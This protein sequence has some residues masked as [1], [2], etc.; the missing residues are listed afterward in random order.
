MFAAF[1]DE[2]LVSVCALLFLLVFFSPGDAFYALVKL[3]PV[4]LAICLVKEVYRAKK[5]FGGLVIIFPPSV[6]NGDE[7]GKNRFS[8]RRLTVAPPSPTLPT[9]APWP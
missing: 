8:F 4:Y 5:I 7:N 6:E 9:L 1:A 3:Q 2:F